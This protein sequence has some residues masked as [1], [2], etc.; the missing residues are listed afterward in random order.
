MFTRD[1]ATGGGA[2]I[3]FTTG[4]IVAIGVMLLAGAL[5][6]GCAAFGTSRGLGLT[7]G[8]VPVGVSKMAV[9]VVRADDP[10]MQVENVQVSLIA[11]SPSGTRASSGGNGTPGVDPGEGDPGQPG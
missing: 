4:R 6:Y 9:I 1:Q 5:L 3:R 2:M 7:G 10:S 8:S 11:A